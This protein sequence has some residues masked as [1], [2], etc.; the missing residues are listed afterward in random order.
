MAAC[1]LPACDE[2]AEGSGYAGRFCSTACEMK[3]E[4][5]KASEMERRD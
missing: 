5:L 4:H 3:Y 1:K 2:Q